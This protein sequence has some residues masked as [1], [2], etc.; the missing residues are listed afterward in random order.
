VERDLFGLG[1]VVRGISVKR[2]PPDELHRCQ[3]LRHELRRVEQVDPLERLIVAVGQE[4]QAKLPL[5]ERAVVD[6]VGHVAAV[7]IGVHSG[8][9]LR[10]FPNERMHAGNGLPVELHEGGLASCVHEAEGVDAEPFHRSIGARDRAVRHQPHDVVGRLCVKRH[11]IPERV[12]C[13]LRLRNLAVGVR[14]DGENDIWEFE[15]VL[16]EEHRHVVAD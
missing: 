2:Q 3:L 4:L 9:D 5:E 11:E 14:L 13:G 10:F 7:E 8:R 6:S 12:V 16:D 15:P 1:E